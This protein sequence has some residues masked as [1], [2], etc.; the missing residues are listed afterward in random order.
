M[1]KKLLLFV[2]AIVAILAVVFVIKSAYAYYK[3]LK[4]P[5]LPVSYA[6][7]EH[8]EVV[9]RSGSVS[10]FVEKTRASGFGEVLQAFGGRFTYD[11]MTSMVDSLSQYDVLFQEIFDNNEFVISVVPDKNENPEILISI[12]TRLTNLRSLLKSIKAAIK[13]KNIV[14]AESEK[15]FSGIYQLSRGQDTVWCYLNRG[16]FT[17]GFNPESVN[18]SYQALTGKKSLAENKTFSRLNDVSGKKVDAVLFIRNDLLYAAAIG[19]EGESAANN[20]FESWS[21][22]DLSIGKEKL[23]LSGFTIADKPTWLINQT[24]VSNDFTGKMPSGFS[25]VYSMSFNNVDQYLDDKNIGDTLRVISRGR[26]SQLS[27]VNVFRIN[28]NL[29]SWMGNE[30]I[31]LTDVRHGNRKAPLVLIESNNPGLASES[32]LPFINPGADP[33]PKIRI[34]GI[35]DRL[36]GKM[37]AFSD[38]AYC[39]ITPDYLAFSSSYQVLSQ[40]S[41]RTA[42]TGDL[43]S[44]NQLPLDQLNEKSNLMFYFS[45]GDIAAKLHTQK[46]RGQDK[47][48]KK[49]TGFLAACR[50]ITLQYSGGD[51]LVYTQG[52]ILFNPTTLA[53]LDSATQ[54]AE[55]PEKEIAQVNGIKTE[56]KE[57]EIHEE[58]KNIKEEKFKTE[59]TAHRPEVLTGPK[60]GQNVIAVTYQDRIV[61]FDDSGKAAWQFKTRGRPGGGIFEIVHPET[62]R[63]N[64]AILTDTHLHLL[65]TDGKEEKTSPVKLPAGNAGQSSVFDYDKKRDY[66]LVY[67]SKDGSLYNI[68]IAGKEVP[69]W[70]RPK[71]NLPADQPLFI[72]TS[73]KDYLVFLFGNGNLKITDRR[74]KVRI[75]LPDK[76]LKSANAGVFENKTN[77]KGTFLTVS[78]AGNLLYIASD[79]KVSES[80]FGDFGTD[81]FFVYTDFDSD[82]SMDFVFAGKG[83]IGIYTRLKKELAGY[84]VKNAEFGKPFIYSAS[85]GSEWIAFRET[86]SGDIILFKSK[87]ARPTILKLKSET[88]PVIFNPGGQK[89]EILVTMRNGKPV[90]TAMK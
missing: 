17:L 21:A 22:L 37:F 56:E 19:Q 64:Y 53:H 58:P 36:F 46:S 3:Y 47:D 78:K 38:S 70:S 63:R 48:L 44:S 52:S 32:L 57:T 40:Y 28:E 29:K 88:D 24:P 67:P 31:V 84:S 73:G 43:K 27:T 2:A 90:F 11:D 83:R 82:N 15:K 7:P 12:K 69:D 26:G 35:F 49:W 86:N 77:S 1:K 33:L 23:L 30:I 39:L 81:P 85:G 14:F 54:K 42:G 8:A 79:G 72:R 71:I 87:N 50:H 25:T 65:S 10:A 45:A 9:L 68:T 16:I 60:G 75:P 13:D 89:P 34:K 20:F 51:S 18:Q 6:V 74:G 4:Q 55:I 5:V 41:S 62:G 61:L 76:F 59:A 80:S 66:R